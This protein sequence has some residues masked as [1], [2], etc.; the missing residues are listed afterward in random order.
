MLNEKITQGKVLSELLQPLLDLLEDGIVVHDEERRIYLVNKATEK[1]TGL[2]KKKIIGM[3]CHKAFR[4]G[5]LCGG[6]CAFPDGVSAKSN[7]NREVEVTFTREDG[8]DRR[9]KV[10]SDP[11]LI[12]GKK[13]GVLAVIRD[14]TEINDLRRRVNP[15]RHF[16]GMI[17]VSSALRDVFETIRSVGASEY[18]VLITGESGTGKELAA[19]AI[20]KESRRCD[21]PFVPVN[22]GALPENIL[23][24]E[25]F[26]HVRGAFTG[27]IRDKK[28]RFELAEDGTLFLDE[29][30]DLP[31]L[32]QVKLLRVIQEKTFERVGGEKSITANVRIIAATNRDLRQMVAEGSFREDLYYRICVV[33]IELP[34]LRERKEDIPFLV[35]DILKTINRE[36]QNNF[37]RVDDDAMGIILAHT[38]P[39]NIRELINA[40]QYASVRGS[41]GTIEA[42][43][44]PYE[45]RFG[46]SVETSIRV[47]A[48]G[49][50]N[51]PFSLEFPRSSETAILQVKRAR[52]NLT[53]EAVERALTETGGNK[54]KAAKLLGVGRATLY[55]FMDLNR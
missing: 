24:S 42:K 2:S 22:C 1:I 17:G 33:P 30:G 45:I 11:V 43:Y 32:V 15:K 38:W 10:R 49:Q 28:G 47:R 14:I 4:P 44:L 35:E 12:G 3:D 21:G 18:P 23:E 46:P 39:G 40:L 52:A 19:A 6:A 36:T 54:V 5:G 53:A 31:L 26:G 48:S 20:H 13:R 55:R 16:H 41:G 8:E 25:L 29:V 50:G 9:I 7:V 51:F 27:A 34:P 37:A